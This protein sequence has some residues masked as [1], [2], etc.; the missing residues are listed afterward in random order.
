MTD[1]YIVRTPDRQAATKLYNVLLDLGQD[2]ENSVLSAWVVRGHMYDDIGGII[3][4]SCDN[5]YMC[6]ISENQLQTTHMSIITVE[7]YIYIVK[8]NIGRIAI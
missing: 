7:D 2:V 8:P 6:Y 3:F 1:Y 5:K 4:T